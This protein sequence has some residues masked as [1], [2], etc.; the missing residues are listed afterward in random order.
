M[1]TKAFGMRFRNLQASNLAMV[2]KQ[3][4]RL[5]TN[6][7]SLVAKI[8][9]AKYYPNGDVLKAKLGSNPSY[10]WRSIYNNLEVIR[11]GTRWRMGN[12]KMIHIQDDKW[13]LTPTTYKVI[14]PPRDLDD[15]RMVS[16]LVDDGTKSQKS[17]LV[18]ELF[19]PFEVETILRIP[20]SHNLLD[21]KIIWVGNKR[22]GGVSC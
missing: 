7:N 1:S 17:N 10:A 2:A 21:D 22:G 15:F 6:Q 18:R 13:L 16:Y 12:G 8:F 5:L 3:G 9:K 14:S 20:L 11:R 19:L 4:W